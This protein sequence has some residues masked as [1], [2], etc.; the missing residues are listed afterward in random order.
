MNWLLLV[1]GL[2]LAQDGPVP[3]ERVDPQS[4]PVPAATEPVPPT[5]G[6][7]AQEQPQRQS[8]RI[9]PQEARRDIAAPR[10]RP[11]ASIFTDEEYRH[12]RVRSLLVRAMEGRA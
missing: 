8:P 12:A 6:S 10:A 7:P 11:A 4:I 2:S 5:E 1:F 9:D 3:P